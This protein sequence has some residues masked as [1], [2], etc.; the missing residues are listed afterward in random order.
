MAILYGTT[1]DGDS[2]PV[3]VN[4]FGQ[5][6]AQ[7]L[8]GQEGP[9]GPPGLPELPPDPFEGAVLGWKDNTLTWLGGSVPLPAGTYG[10]I[11]EYSDG[12]LTLETSVDLPYLTAIFL[13]D[14]QGNVYFYQ[15]VS[16]AIINAN[17]Y[18]SCAGRNNGG[19]GT[20][21]EDVQLAFNGDPSDGWVVL[22]N[23]LGL[24]PGWTFD[25]PFFLNAGDSVSIDTT[26]Q[27]GS[28]GRWDIQVVLS[29]GTVLTNTSPSVLLSENDSIVSINGYNV[30]PNPCTLHG[31]KVNNQ[32]LLATTQSGTQLLLAD[33]TGLANFRVG[34]AV[35]SRDDVQTGVSITA[36]NPSPPS[37]TV[38]GGTWEVGQFVIGPSK[39]G[40]GTVQSTTGNVIVLRENNDE[41]CVGKYVTAPEQNLAARYVYTEELKKKLL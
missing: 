4:E 10:P 38:S 24:R 15:P 34:D 33:D 31:I 26:G 20:N 37:M 13:S 27:N 41:W 12:I 29:S 2:L 28:D 18:L 19:W 6:V 30:G 40:E 11:T 25:T 1:A 39:S 8:P 7:G 21:V 16:S 9:Q 3:E 23:G 22:T 32:Y 5:L 17:T 36:I 14:D 35:Q